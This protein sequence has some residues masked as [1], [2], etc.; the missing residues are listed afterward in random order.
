MNYLKKRLVVCLIYV[1]VY[2]LL[3]YNLRKQESLNV[4]M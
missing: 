2:D 1:S 4:C 3:K